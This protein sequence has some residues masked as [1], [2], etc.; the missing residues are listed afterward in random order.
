MNDLWA[1]I[2]IALP[3]LAIWIAA[4]VEVVRRHDLSGPRKVGWVAVLILLP[5]VALAV[6]V[7]V[8]PPRSARV[9]GGPADHARAETLVALAERRQR[10][11]IDDDD[12]L[13][14]VRSMT[15]R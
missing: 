15:S 4:V 6:Y 9:S 5:V 2:V 7:V 3:L 8:R 14:E 11:E 1:I 13:T 10:G 12:Y